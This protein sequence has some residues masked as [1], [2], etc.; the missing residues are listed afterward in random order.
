MSAEGG[1][2][3]VAD[4]NQSIGRAILLLEQLAEAGGELGISELSRRTGLAKSVVSRLLRPLL[5]ARYLEQNPVT[6]HYRIGL[7]LFEVGLLYM[8]Q[9]GM[10]RQ[11]LAMLDGLARETGYT[12]YLGILDGGDCV[13]LAAFEGARRVRV[14]VSPGQ[15]A[16]AHVTAM[17]KAILARLDEAERERIL[18]AHWPAPGGEWT[19]LPPE[20]LR[21]DLEATARR[22]YALVL[23][24]GFPGIL[25]VG[26]ALP[27]P[28]AG[29]P[30]AV[31]LDLPAI[32]TDHEELHRLG[33]MLMQ[34]VQAMMASFP[35]E[36]YGVGLGDL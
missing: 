23:D 11:A 1:W 33:R 25:S 9:Q 20:A 16:P 5:E 36:A 10:Q 34:R 13:V 32:E 27:L 29:A 17:G 28:A 35:Q 18:V 8:R 31:S 24:D 30:M 4:Q 22:G 19:I 6:R 21:A 12:A 2:E 7:R 15:R 26:V 3:R 14:A